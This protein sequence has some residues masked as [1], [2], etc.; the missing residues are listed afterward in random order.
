MTTAFNKVQADAQGPPLI[1][2]PP[3]AP[4][5]PQPPT[6][7]FSWMPQR[8]NGLSSIREIV[9]NYPECNKADS[10]AI[11]KKLDFIVK[12][13][14]DAQWVATNVRNELT[15]RGVSFSNTQ[16]LATMFLQWGAWESG[17][18]ESGSRSAVQNNFFGAQ[19]GAPGSV[20]CPSSVGRTTNSCFPLAMGFAQQLSAVL[21]MVPRTRANPNTSNLSYLAQ[22][23]NMLA[24]DTGASATTLL[25]GIASFGWNSVDPQYG[26]TVTAGIRLSTELN[27]MKNNGYISK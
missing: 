5:P 23:E 25:Q 16:G 15:Q 20:P 13:Y 2:N 19:R 6:W 12:Y 18:M 3:P 4:A 11:D 14:S 24:S 21:S 26:T 1:Y 17:W 10:R 22:L 27:C 9:T 8:P 7:F